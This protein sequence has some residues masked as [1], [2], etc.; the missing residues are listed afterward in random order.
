MWMQLKDV[1]G[2]IA[3]AACCLISAEV[4]ANESINTESDWLDD[5]Q[6]D[7]ALMLYSEVDRVSALE[8]VFS[9]KKDFK[10]EHIFSGKLVIDSLTGASANG[11]VSQPNVQTF[12]RPSGNAQYTVKANETPLDD[13]FKDTRVQINGQWTSPFSTDI[14]TSFGG[15]LSKEYDYLSLSVN[16]SISWDTNFNNTSYTLGGSYAY[17][18]I[19]P[20]GGIPIALTKHYSDPAFFASQALFDQAYSS[21]IA[22]TSSDKQ[23]FD[24][25]FGVTQVWTKRLITLVNVGIS[26]VDG[27]ITDPFKIVSR[28]QSDG[29]TLD[30]INESRPDSR[31][32]Q[33]YFMQ[34][35]YHFDW[36]IFDVSYRYSTDDW[37]INS[38]TLESRIHIPSKLT[39]Y[40]QPHI[41]IYQ[42]SA[43]EFYAPFILSQN[44]TP[45]YV[46]ADYRIGDLNAITL[47]LKYGDQTQAG[48]PYS[49][50]LEYYYQTS[51]DSG[52][53]RPGVLQQQNLYPSV[54]AIV[55]QY[56]YRF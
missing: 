18:E 35:K 6:I 51:E 21:T 15:Q 14:T 55:V 17:D 2:L 13:T 49:I 40:W 43:A 19:E 46:S 12:T 11:A 42:Q 25:L 31:N 4:I 39:S 26:K 37:E 8:A 5:W 45:N 48:N 47:G 34:S 3:S 50:R 20:E 1:S 7:S 33:S 22:T 52:H 38:H 29:Y 28:V 16:G 54:S 23:T 9:F 10:D 56:N 32:K 24:L 27:Y 41:R 30:N 53:A 44:E 36:A